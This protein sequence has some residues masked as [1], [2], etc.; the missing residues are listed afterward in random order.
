MLCVGY[1][2]VVAEVFCGLK[3]RNVS[4]NPTVRLLMIHGCSAFSCIDRTLEPLHCSGV[5]LLHSQRVLRAHVE[6]SEVGGAGPS[7]VVGRADGER[8]RGL[9]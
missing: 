1:V 5:F 8:A 2:D 3:K 7:H 4:Q 6:L 9:S